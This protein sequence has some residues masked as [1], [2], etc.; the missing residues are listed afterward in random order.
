MI[1]V[2]KSTNVSTRTIKRPRGRPRKTDTSTTTKRPRGR[3]RKTDTSTTTKRPRGR[4]RKTDTSTT[5]KRPRGR[6]RKTDTSTTTKRPR[7]RPRKTDTSTTTKRP[8]GRPRKT[9]TSTTTKRPR[10]RPRKTD[11]STTTKRP[12][13]RPRKTDTSTTTK[14]PRGRPR[15]TDTSTTTKRPRGRPRKTD[16]STTTKRPR[17]RPRK[18]D[19]STTTKR[20][21]GRP[22]K[23]DTST[24]TKRPR[25]RPR[26]TDTSTTTK[27][28]RG[29]PRKTDTSTT[30][31]RPRGRPKKSLLD[32]LSELAAE[33][34]QDKLKK[35]SDVNQLE[36]TK[37]QPTFQAK[38]MVTND[39]VKID[40]AELNKTLKQIDEKIA[41]VLKYYIVDTDAKEIRSI[42]DYLMSDIKDIVVEN[43]KAN[44]RVVYKKFSKQLESR[45]I[46]GLKNI[47]IVKHV[48]YDNSST[49]DY[50]NLIVI[51]DHKNSSHAYD[52]ISDIVQ[53]VEVDRHKLY[54]DLNILSVSEANANPEFLKHTTTLLTR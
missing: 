1:L 12:R 19:T 15:K 53:S 37:N 31:K 52:I 44:Q 21:R 29:R 51:Y 46:R 49:H 30:T 54:I 13:G 28:P 26:K 33:I 20:P 43:M 38:H 2:K 45:I 7:G 34:E 3:P 5:T 25:G 6:P 14:R 47:N 40:K 17:G 36:Q 18:T 11:T 9:D 50:M 41:K 39:S 48:C 27:R 42:T 23:T 10:G 4:P 32:S 35:A 24:T 16:T 8:R 22:R